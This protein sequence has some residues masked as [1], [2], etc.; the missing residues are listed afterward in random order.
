MEVKDA[1]KRKK[2]EKFIYKKIEGDKTTAVLQVPKGNEGD[3]RLY[4]GESSSGFAT[5]SER[6]ESSN[7]YRAKQIARHKSYASPADSLSRGDYAKLKQKKVEE[8]PKKKKRK[9]FFSRK[10]R[11]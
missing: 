9:K 5:T 11:K 10:S 7:I 3:S 8:P 2:Q 1:R 6:K 4:K